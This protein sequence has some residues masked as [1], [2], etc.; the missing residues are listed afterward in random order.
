MTITFTPEEMVAALGQVF[1][2]PEEWDAMLSKEGR[3]AL[4]FNVSIMRL[5]AEAQE[6]STDDPDGE[7]GKEDKPP[8][9]AEKRRKAKAEKKESPNGVA[10]PVEEPVEASTG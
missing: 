9:R 4:K 3:L 6:R 5:E 2:N 7:S 10:E 1:V 8:T